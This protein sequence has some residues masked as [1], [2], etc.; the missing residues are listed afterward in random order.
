MFPIPATAA[1]SGA[2]RRARSR[3]QR[4]E[5]GDHR[6]EVGRLGEDVRAEARGARGRSSS[7]TG[8]CQS[9]RLLRRCR[10]GRAT[11][12]RRGSRPRGWT[13]QRPVIRRWLR[14][15]TPPS[16]DR[17]RF[18][19]TA[20]TA[21]SRRPSRRCAMRLHGRARM[22]RLDRDALADEHLEPPGRAVRVRLPR[23]ARLAYGSAGRAAIAAWRRRGRSSSRRA[24]LGRRSRA[25]AEGSV[26]S[27][28]STA[29]AVAGR[30]RLARVQA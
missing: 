19:P 13:R 22:R 6:V 15:V 8:P 18:L 27:C 28:G 1:G 9:T 20:S 5:V 21:S 14:S 23:H 24:T 16:K 10:A 12:G 4:A 30:R 17:K 26:R 7:S 29:R 25:C 2:P 3:R 11:A